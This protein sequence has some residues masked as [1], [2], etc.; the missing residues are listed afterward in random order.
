MEEKI[1]VKIN[2][3][4]TKEV[5]K[6]VYLGSVVEKSGKIQNEINEIKASE[7]YHL[8]KSLLW[9]KGIDRKCK[10]TT[11]NVYFKKMEQRHG[12]VLRER[13]VNY[14]QLR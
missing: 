10:I 7:L 8:A 6:F 12:H 3:K 11:F 1:M 13:A 5:D 4:G 9:N 2:G 14:K